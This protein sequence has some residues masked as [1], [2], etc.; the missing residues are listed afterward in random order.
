MV[1]LPVEEVPELAPAL[2]KNK[3]PLRAP[4]RATT[5][6]PIGAGRASGAVSAQI[7][8][9]P[10][11]PRAALAVSAGARAPQRPAIPGSS[12][13]PSTP[14]LGGANASTARAEVRKPAAPTGLPSRNGS[15]PAPN[16]PA[17][18]LFATNAAAAAPKAQAAVP[19]EDLF[20]PPTLDPEALVADDEGD[21]HDQDGAPQLPI[22]NE[23]SGLVSLAHLQAAASGKAVGPAM[24]NGHTGRQRALPAVEPITAMDPPVPEN[25]GSVP[26][27]VVAGAAP[28][29]TSPL[30]KWAA[31]V[32]LIACMGLGGGVWYL[33]THRPPPDTIIVT[34]PRRQTDDTPITVTDP[35][36]G[37]QPL[38]AADPKR[39]SSSSKKV[40]AS[41]APRP[42]VPNNK[43]G[44]GLSGSQRALADLYKDDGD[45]ATP[46][47]NAGIGA[48]AGGGGQVSQSAILAVVTANRRA[49]NLCY[50]RVLKHD[51]SLK[52]GRVMVQVSVGISGRVTSVVIPEAQYAQS[53]L[54]QCFT[55]A[56]KRWNFPASDAPYSTE[57]PFIL[58]AQ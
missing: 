22:S 45:K 58:Q 24:V 15:G 34:E 44:D 49:L 41:A 56:V 38:V 42:T 25:A 12:L 57:F 55:Q 1:W 20:S 5:P 27:V 50:E 23:A 39:P 40:A 21:G 54:G 37:N 26:V 46:H 28:K 52:Q 48:R 53:E 8:K 29:G 31:L 6:T 2:V 13:R 35:A 7:A 11:G 51:Q 47:L 19:A 30:F 16:A 36:T 14:G 18:P 3:P 43:P 10:S 33:L 9:D 32:A 17:A 4:V